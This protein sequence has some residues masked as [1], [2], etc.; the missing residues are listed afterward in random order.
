MLIVSFND[1]RYYARLG[2]VGD[3]PL[4]LQELAIAIVMQLVAEF[5]VDIICCR[6]EETSDELSLSA[7]WTNTNPYTLQ[8]SVSVLAWMTLSLWI[9]MLSFSGG[10]SSCPFYADP[11]IHRVYLC[12]DECLS[13]AR[14]SVFDYICNQ[15]L[16]NTTNTTIP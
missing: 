15:L 6:I 16:H 11:Y 2:Y 3:T 1:Q 14:Y 7:S 4:D 9:L 12:G 8:F 5:I 13:G 10:I